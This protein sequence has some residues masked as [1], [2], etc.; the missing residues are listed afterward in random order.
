MDN[1]DPLS[2]LAGIHLPEP[3]G[4]WPLAPGWWILLIAIL[5]SAFFL[6]RTLRAQWKRK[7]ICSFAIKELD[8]CLAAFTAKASQADAQAMGQLS[9]NYV[10]EVNAVLRRVAL[11]HYPFGKIASL[12]GDDWIAFLRNGGD[13]TLLDE[14][15][16]NAISQGRFARQWDVD[17]DALYQMAHRWISSL[18]ASSSNANDQN[19]SSPESTAV[20][21]H[22]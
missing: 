13:A 7:R 18:Y 6:T 16:A 17:P 2:E 12:S 21:E 22:A 20:S 11:K 4:I 3:V 19:Q 1:P 9:L 5:V 15:M 10:S 14:S 8:K